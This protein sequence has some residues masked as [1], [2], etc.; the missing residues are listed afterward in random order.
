MVEQYCDAARPALIDDGPQ[1]APGPQ[2]ARQA[3]IDQSMEN[4]HKIKYFHLVK[5]WLQT[6]C[7]HF[8]TLAVAVRN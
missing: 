1:S 2:L 7:V 5:I 8:A 4:I 3:S 6:F